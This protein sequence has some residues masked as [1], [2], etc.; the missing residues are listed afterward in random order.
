M[1]NPTNEA[2][3]C[4]LAPTSS[5]SFASNFMRFQNFDNMDDDDVYS[6]GEST[7]LDHNGIADR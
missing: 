1:S 2:I 5:P 7:A 6:V 4:K 3:V